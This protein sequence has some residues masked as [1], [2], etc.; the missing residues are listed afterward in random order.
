[1]LWLVTATPGSGKTLYLLQQVK[2]Q[3]D[4][5]NR[6]VYYHG[7]TLTELGQKVLQWLPL[8]KPE[9]WYTLPAG[10]IIVI[11]ECQK[12]FPPRRTGTHV[13]KHVSEFETH[14]HKGFDIWLVTQGPKLL[15]AHIRELVNKHTHLRRIFGMQAAQVINWDCCEI[16]PNSTGAAGRSLDK[17][18]F[19]YP[20]QVYQWYKSAELHTHKVKIPRVVWI[21]LFALL[22]AIPALYFSVTLVMGLADKPAL[23]A[24]SAASAPVSVAPGQ[25]GPRAQASAPSQMTPE[26]IQASYIPK[27]PDRPETAPRYADMAQP[28][29]FPRLSGCVKSRRSC[30]C[31]TQQATII[32]VE[33]AM[34]QE[35]AERPRFDDYA[36]PAQ[37]QS[38]P[39][40][41][42]A[43][44]QGTPTTSQRNLLLSM[45]DGRGA[46]APAPA[47]TPAPQ[48]QGG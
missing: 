40:Q 36:Q 10:A 6:Q 33:P 19:M 29:T 46:P 28:T 23:K 9:E 43:V 27:L 38:T 7:I 24:N 20:R 26:Q 2:K 30:K 1:M 34:C 22:V 37:Q 44:P 18:R 31:Y 21:M 41:L 12:I 25:I 48:A 5:E 32:D 14:R 8:E 13:P 3:A 47:A 11:D 35:L 15:D 45:G 39:S 17:W 16:S 42:Q 4:T